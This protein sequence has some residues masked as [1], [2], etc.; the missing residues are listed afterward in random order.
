[1]TTLDVDTVWRMPKKELVSLIEGGQLPN[2]TEKIRFYAPSFIYYKTD[3]FRSS[4]HAFPSISI[5][6][7][8][9]ALNCQHCNGKVLGTMLPAQTPKDLFDL[10]AKLK[11][12]GAVGCLISGGCLPDGSVPVNEFIDTIAKIKKTLGLTVVTHTGV[13]DFDTA[14][15]LKEAGVDAALIDIVGSNETIHEVYHLDV[16]VEDFDR[17]LRA[18][19]ESGIPFVPHVIVGL[20]YGKLRGELEALKMISRYSPSAVITIAFMPIRGTPMEKVSPPEPEDIVRVLACARILMSETPLVLG[21]MRPKGEHRRR[22]DSLAVG[23][24]V[25]AVAF[26]TEE[27]IRLAESMN[28]E[29]SFSSLCCSQIFVDKFKV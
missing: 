15:R 6:G 10:C 4:P 12:D 25:T 19:H 7:S 20:H 2:R 29:M 17:S 8:S 14:K 9:C 11:N 13:V 21:C 24:G 22:T 27:A 16:S 18:F 26:P 5:T 1:M 3:Y 28:L 23:A